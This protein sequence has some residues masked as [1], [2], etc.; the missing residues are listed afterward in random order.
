MWAT[1]AL[2][3]AA[4]IYERTGRTA[5]AKDLLAMVAKNADRKSQREQAEQKLQQLEQRGKGGKKGTADSVG[6]P[7]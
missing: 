1:T 6:Y 7:F 3:R 2:Y 4:L 5:P